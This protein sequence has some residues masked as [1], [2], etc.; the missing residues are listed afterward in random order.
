[1]GVFRS[2]RR[3]VG[4]DLDGNKYYEILSGKSGRPRREVETQ[5]KHEQ[6]EDG[7]IPIEWESWIRG[8]R[9]NPPTHDELISK[10]QQ[11]E[12]LSQ[13]V[14]KVEAEEMERK[15]KEQDQA[16][17]QQGHASAPVYE[18][19]GLKS[20]PTRTGDTFQPGSWTPGSKT[21]QAGKGS[22]EEVDSFEPEAWNPG[23]K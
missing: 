3:L 21:G 19:T 15:A 8:K 20:E 23:K 6:Y 4:T 22:E 12:V 18:K 5:L 16:T 7:T 11:R 17:R 1:M 9:D 13:R 10:L 14:K 2:G